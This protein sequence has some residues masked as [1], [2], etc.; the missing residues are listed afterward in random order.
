MSRGSALLL[1]L[2]LLGAALRASCAL[3]QA[4][5]LDPSLPADGPPTLLPDLAYDGAARLAW[6][7]GLGAGGAADL[8]AARPFLGVEL[9]LQTLPLVPRIGAQTVR[10]VQAFYARQLAFTRAP[11]Q[12]LRDR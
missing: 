11:P 1:A 6:L 7:P 4:P 12:P 9:N 5:P 3:L 2:L 8:V 10:E